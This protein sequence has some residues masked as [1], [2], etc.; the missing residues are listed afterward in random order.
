[1]PLGPVDLPRPA[2]SCRHAATP[3]PMLPKAAYDARAPHPPRG[4]EHVRTRHTPAVT[5]SPKP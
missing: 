1:M 3:L 2:Q 5:G 4:L